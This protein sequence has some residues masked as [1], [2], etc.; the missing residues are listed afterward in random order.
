[1][2]H[3]ARRLVSTATQCGVSKPLTTISKRGFRAAVAEK[4]EDKSISVHVRH[5]DST[6]DLPFQVDG[7]DVTVDVAYS[8]LNYKVRHLFT[9][10]NLKMESLWLCVCDNRMAWY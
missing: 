6:K 7:S 3:L 1:M 5:V 10:I 8:C 2:H 9:A 4:N